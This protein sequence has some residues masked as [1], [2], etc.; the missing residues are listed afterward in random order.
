MVG[1]KQQTVK[2]IM[3]KSKITVERVNGAE[4]IFIER[5]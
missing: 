1:I 4:G 5:T 2:K 3:T